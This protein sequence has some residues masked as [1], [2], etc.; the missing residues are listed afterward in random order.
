MRPTAALLW[1]RIAKARILDIARTVFGISWASARSKTKKAALADAM[2][3]AFAAG[4]TPVGLSAQMHGAALAWTPPGFA[5]FDTGRIGDEA[6]DAAQAETQPAPDTAKADSS[7][8]P[9]GGAVPETAPTAETAEATVANEGNGHAIPAEAEAQA[10]PDDP[11]GEA[12]TAADIAGGDDPMPPAPANGHHPAPDPMEI[13]EF[14]R[15]VH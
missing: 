6:E 7:A 11:G 8:E 4:D 3:T 5:A 14:L 15:R 10:E 12:A 1:S 2:E 13:P 9:E